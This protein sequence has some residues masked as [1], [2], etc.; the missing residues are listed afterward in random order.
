[1]PP[2]EGMDSGDEAPPQP[3]ISNPPRRGAHPPVSQQRRNAAPPPKSAPPPA[4]VAKKGAAAAGAAQ[5]AGS[6][7]FGFGSSLTVKGELS[8]MAALNWRILKSSF[9]FFFTLFQLATNV[10]TN[11]SI[12]AS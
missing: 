1:M 5:N 12:Q 7:F 2:L 6:D 9:S 4:P 11:T 10:L 8:F 3:P